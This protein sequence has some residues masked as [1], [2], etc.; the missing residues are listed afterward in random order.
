MV[1]ALSPDPISVA[2]HRATGTY[3]EPS[4]GDTALRHHAAG[5]TAFAPRQWLA[6]DRQVSAKHYP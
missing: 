4:D 5:A 6:T 2:V 3:A 1:V